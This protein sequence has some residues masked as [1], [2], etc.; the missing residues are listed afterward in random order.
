[1]RLRGEARTR[2]YAQMGADD[3]SRGPWPR[4]RATFASAADHR[5]YMAGWDRQRE[6]AA[7]YDAER[8]AAELVTP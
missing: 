5:A 4:E 7:A 8:R 3:Y 1:M 6:R 2:H